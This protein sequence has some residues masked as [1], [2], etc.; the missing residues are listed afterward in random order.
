M[1]ISRPGNRL[2]EAVDLRD[3]AGVEKD[4]LFDQCLEIVRHLLGGE[5]DMAGWDAQADRPLDLVA[6]AGV[7]VEAG[8]GE[9]LEHGAAG[10]GL[11]GIAGG[12]AEGVWEVE[13]EA[14]LAFQGGLIVDEDGRA[15]VAADRMGESRL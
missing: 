8:G 3:R 10:A 12:Q 5:L 1:E 14:G 6:A 4:P 7:D 2:A 11:H 15:E 13:H 9:H